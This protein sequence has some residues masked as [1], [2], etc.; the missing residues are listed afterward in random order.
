MSVKRTYR[1]KG[2]LKPGTYALKGKDNKVKDGNLTFDGII[3]D[4]LVDKGLATTEDNCVYNLDCCTDF[5]ITYQD[6]QLCI[7][8]GGVTECVEIEGGGGSITVNNALTGT[9][10]VDNPVQWGGDLVKNTT[11]DGNNNYNVT[12]QDLTRFLV[13]VL[14]ASAGG[15]LRVSGLQSEPAFLR[16]RNLTND[17]WMTI[18]LDYNDV[19]TFGYQTGLELIGFRVF[20]ETQE[21]SLRSK[22]VIDGDVSVGDVWTCTDA[23]E[24]LGEWQPASAAITYPDYEDDAAAA[25]GGVAVGE[26]YSVTDTNPYGLADGTLKKR[27]T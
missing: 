25:L 1:H 18:D 12:F 15:T 13:T 7:T 11:V 16:H 8:V 20:P 17:T 9:G 14:G 23:T 4:F 6:N 2:W 26:I 24:G 5:T 21:L 3:G 19:S 10:E 22:G 27:R